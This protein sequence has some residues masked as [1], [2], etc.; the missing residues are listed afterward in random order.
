LITFIGSG[1]QDAALSLVLSFY[2][3]L[4]QQILSKMLQSF[5]LTL[6]S[7]YARRF[8]IPDQYFSYYNPF[9]FPVEF[10][11]AQHSY[12]FRYS[13]PLGERMYQPDGTAKASE[14]LPGW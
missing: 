6:K 3:Q 14:W 13:K 11:N 10:I 1:Q 5:L 4:W 2:I 9:C 12:L 7:I 8:T